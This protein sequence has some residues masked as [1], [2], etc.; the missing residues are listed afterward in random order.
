MV[1]LFRNQALLQILIEPQLHTADFFHVQ[2]QGRKLPA[3]VPD[4]TPLPIQS[5]QPVHGIVHVDCHADMGLHGCENHT[6]HQIATDG[7]GGT[8]ASVMLVAGAHI[9]V[10]FPAVGGCRTMNHRA[11]T[12]GTVDHAGKRVDFFAVP[13]P[14]GIHAQKG[15]DKLKL[16]RG[17][18]GFVRM[19]NPVPF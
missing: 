13:G 2:L 8:A 9:V 14:A 19:F 6:L 10:V 1:F 18:D 16:R 15:L 17:D 7:M 12:I 4:F 3:D 11:M 5:F